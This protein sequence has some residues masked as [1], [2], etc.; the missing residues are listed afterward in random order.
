MIHFTIVNRHKHQVGFE[1]RVFLRIMSYFELG[2][3]SVSSGIHQEW[4]V[5]NITKMLTFS[6]LLSHWAEATLAFCKS[7][8]KKKKNTNKQKQNEEDMFITWDRKHS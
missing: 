1:Y 3:D 7:K 6:L 8:S 4:K 2:W 5:V